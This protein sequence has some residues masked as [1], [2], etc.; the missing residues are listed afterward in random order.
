MAHDRLHADG[1]LYARAREFGRAIRE[2]PEME[3]YE[4]SRAAMN[5]DREVQA[6]LAELNARHQQYVARQKEGQLTLEDLSGLRR[7]QQE[8]QSHPRVKAA[9][10]DWQK[11]ADLIREANELVSAALGLDFGAL[12]APERDSCC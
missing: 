5:S 2:S 6:L 8:F 4:R 7:A 10:E 12:C 1:Q 3:H 9:R 11:V